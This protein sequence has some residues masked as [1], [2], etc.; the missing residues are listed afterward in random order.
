[1]AEEPRVTLELADGIATL[2]L[3][4]PE[5][6]NAIDTPMRQALIEALDALTENQDVNCL[7]LTG[8]GE[9]S[10]VS[11]ADIQ[12]LK[13]RE[14]PDALPGYNSE[15]FRRVERFPMP[16]IAAIRGYALG[17]GCELAMACD[18]R[19]AGENAKLG[20]PE[21][22]L[23]IMAAAGGTY[24]LP[25]LVGLARAKELLFTGATIDAATALEIGLVNRVVPDTEVISEAETLAKE[26]GK[27]SRHA[28][29][30]TKRAISAWATSGQEA[31]RAMEDLCQHVLYDDP[32]KAERMQTFLERR[33]KKVN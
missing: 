30:L 32:D 18:L 26:I 29:R 8:A 6:R 13:N 31:W 4:R 17:G 1:M 12:E 3:N 22:A 14:G 7:I 24:R 25:Q 16:T 21:V 23:G 28:V 11:G 19:V 27:N 5:T 9:K 33:T 15:L 2:T 10:F 20:Q